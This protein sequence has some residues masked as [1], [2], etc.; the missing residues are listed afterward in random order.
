MLENNR[1][2]EINETGVHSNGRRT[3]INTG[4]NTRKTEINAGSG[5]RRTAVN[6]NNSA[7]R[8]EINPN[9]RERQT[10]P[11]SEDEHLNSNSSS[12]PT[13]KKYTT[14][15]N[16]AN[17]TVISI[18]NPNQKTGEAVLYLCKNSKGEQV[19]LKYYNRTDIDIDG[20]RKLTEILNR[21]K[22]V[23]TTLDLG[24]DNGHFYEVM[25]YYKNGSLRDRMKRKLFSEEEIKKDILPRMVQI[26][27]NLHNAS[28][29][30][31]D[32]K[33]E[34]IL[35]ADDG[36]SLVLIDFG[37]S[38]ITSGSNNTTILTEVG[39]TADYRAPETQ[40]GILI[41][42]SDYYSLG[43]TLFTLMVGSTPTD[44]LRKQED[45]ERA[46]VLSVIPRVNGMSDEMY[47]LIDG[48]TY[49]DI[50][51]RHDRS[52]PNR[53]IAQDVRDWLSGKKDITPPVP[54]PEE[55]LIKDLEINIRFRNKPYKRWQ[56]LILEMA[57]NWN[58]GKQFLLNT[59]MDSLPNAVFQLYSGE[60]SNLERKAA[61][62]R[63]YQAIGNY[64]E[65]K[66]SNDDNTFFSFIYFFSSG[67][68]GW[69][70]NTIFWKGMSFQ[71]AEALGEAVYRSAMT[72]HNEC[73]KQFEGLFSDYNLLVQYFDQLPDRNEKINNF[74]NTIIRL[75]K[76][77][78]GKIS[79]STLM[80]CCFVLR[81]DK[82]FDISPN[83]AVKTPE[84][85]KR[86]VM[87]Q[88]KTPKDLQRM[89]QSI[90][91]DDNGMNTILNSWLNY[92]G[93]TNFRV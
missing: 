19:V 68:Y 76:N 75:L 40:R 88:G 82:S 20:K 26:L 5:N 66:S 58:P 29:Y 86:Y 72:N 44:Y 14:D 11:F 28:V 78:K 10:T 89:Y 74:R 77:T 1:K 6:T 62:G 39:G 90:M 65:R 43:I 32:I 31:S 15:E 73:L 84:E 2:T 64:L 45:V 51:Y 24:T 22:N 35:Y 48:L 50:R 63:L 79:F 46:Q 87:S 55:I 67:E 13:D 71:N 70:L 56:D 37:V 8:T 33:P 54:I 53:W 81:K 85:F 69:G 60:R 3:E 9:N 27:E 12:I 38:V 83:K 49:I 34:N 25:P 80:D 91:V 36:K 92:H 41:D 42:A 4:N 7:R 23:Q 93:V 57:K 47:Q 17:Y 59:G 52:K 61:L 30:H 21:I 16:I 18:L